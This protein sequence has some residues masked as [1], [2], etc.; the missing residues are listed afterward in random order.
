[1]PRRRRATRKRRTRRSGTTGDK[2]PQFLNVVSGATPGN[3]VWYSSL[4]EAP[5]LNILTGG[6]KVIELLKIQI[7][8]IGAA[9]LMNFAI[10]SR[11]L[12]NTNFASFSVAQSH[13][14]KAFV[15]TTQMATTENYR[16]IDLTD[17]NGNGQL[18]PA[19]QI[20]VNIG[21]ANQGDYVKVSFLYR[22]K[23]AS[24]SEYIGIINQYV[25]TQS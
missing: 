14:D 17:E 6:T 8:K 23:N 12:N 2:K 18:Y 16:E 10:G 5:L 9:S 3:N 7:N 19:Q 13:I 22:I 25:V 15:V 11:N 20:Y 21:Q 1:M 4:A 24:M